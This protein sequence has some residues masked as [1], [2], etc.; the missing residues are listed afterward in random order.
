LKLRKSMIMPIDH[1][2]HGSLYRD[3]RL[4]RPTRGICL[5]RSAASLATS[6]SERRRLRGMIH[7]PLSAEIEFAAKGGVREA[8]EMANRGGTAA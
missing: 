3:E 7:G 8:L 2:K 6:A 1:E 5:P 4:L